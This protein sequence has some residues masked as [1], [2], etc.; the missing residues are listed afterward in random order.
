MNDP[1]SFKDLLKSKQGRNERGLALAG[2]GDK[3][4]RE[5][6]EEGIT[7]GRELVDYVGIPSRWSKKRDHPAMFEGW[8][9]KA[10]LVFKE[11][12]KIVKAA[13]TSL[14]DLE[15]QLAVVES[16]LE[17]EEAVNNEMVEAGEPVTEEKVQLPSFSTMYDRHGYNCRVLKAGRIDQLLTTD[18]L[19]RKPMQ[20]SK[21]MGLSCEVL[22]IDFSYKLPRKI[23]VYQGVG[24][25]C[26]IAPTRVWQ[27]YK[28]RTTLRF[29][30]KLA[31]V[32][33]K[34]L[35]ILNVV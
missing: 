15:D 23:H 2:I 28:I 29:I 11:R 4:F 31:K 1:I 30:T 34:P 18:F 3:K 35:T 20:Q 21:M 27:S 25:C 10:R 32:W 13:E 14:R 7:S 24:S 17:L 5:L 19:H 16:Q 12:R 33:E 8:R 6:I 9:A 22:K 26:T